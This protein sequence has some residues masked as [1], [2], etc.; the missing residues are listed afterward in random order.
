MNR[1]L[2]ILISCYACSPYRGS[3]PGM[4]W[5][6]VYG[7]SKS[8]EVHVI[9][10]KEKWEKDIKAFAKTEDIGNI[11]F[12]FIQKKRNRKLRKIW[13][14]SYYWFYRS[15]QKKAHQLAKRLDEKES[16]DIIHQL[17]MVGYREPGYLWKM[18][19]PFVWGPIGGT[20]DVP[21]HLFSVFN[22]HGKLFYGG[23]NVMNTI[24]KHFLRRPRLAAQKRNT[25][26]IAATPD[27]QKDISRLWNRASTTISEIGTDT[28]LNIV[29][30]DRLTN[31]P[32]RI[33]WSGQH[34]TGKALN[35]LLESLALLDPDIDWQLDVLGVGKETRRWKNLA[36]RLNMEKNCK[37]HGWIPQEE[38]LATMQK[39]HLSCI[40]SL[41]D[42]T[43]TVTLESIALG[44]PIVCLDHCGFAH[45]VNETCGI[46]IKVGNIKTIREDFKKAIESLYC[47]ETY[48]KRLSLGAL[49]RAK[50]FSWNEKIKKINTIYSK[51]LDETTNHS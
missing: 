21:W 41:K 47:D 8:H 44:L 24:Q 43:S 33:V 27:I 14:P 38:A 35:I 4:G 20:Q 46:K 22:A 28:L 39:A 5:N 17:N 36:R 18:D 11:H 15:W 51:L 30:N 29:P 37:W 19:K 32:L 7:L 2:K 13:P 25:K 48:R 23:R 26:L 12:H 34:T 3:E 50:D 40:T 16:F 42:L 10:E 6:F 45:V 31:D 9:T 1:P 49:K